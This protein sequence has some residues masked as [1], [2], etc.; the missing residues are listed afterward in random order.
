M[1]FKIVRNDLDA[2]KFSP[3]TFPDDSVV[4]IDDPFYHEDGK[5]L[6]LLMFEPECIKPLQ[7]STIQNAHR[8][9]K[10]YTYNEEVL[11]AAPD[12]AVRVVGNYTSLFP[13]QYTNIDISK[14]EFK[15]SSWATTKVFNGVI[16]HALRVEIYSKQMMFPPT[17]VFFRS[18]HINPPL[19]DIND[20][21][22]MGADFFGGK[23]CLFETFQ[24]GIQIENS[25]QTNLF[26][27]KLLDCLISK[28]IPIYWGCPNISEFFDTTGWIFF[29]NVDELVAKIETLTPDY[30]SKYSDVIEKNYRTALEYADMYKSFERQHNIGLNKTSAI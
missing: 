19:P 16:G 9:Y 3:D 25:R 29:E 5:K 15:I 23:W 8:F 12:R 18:A 2:S 10:I 30:Y 7:Y 20:N 24:F 4:V 1:P 21:P 26:S 13:E 17:C 27:E 11:K 28:T 22:F 14:K 6:I